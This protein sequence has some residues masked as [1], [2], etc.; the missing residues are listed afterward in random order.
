MGSIRLTPTT[1]GLEVRDSLISLFRSLSFSFSLS[2]SLP[3]TFLFSLSLSV[4]KIATAN[5]IQIISRTELRIS[6][7]DYGAPG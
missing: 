4:D 7:R 3:P 5:G 6:G 1:R 2:P